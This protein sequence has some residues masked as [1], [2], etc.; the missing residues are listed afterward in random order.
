[1]ML[2]TEIGNFSSY[3]DLY[4]EMQA[5]GVKEV[6]C[7]VEYWLTDV[8]TSKLTLEAVKILMEHEKGKEELPIELVKKI[9]RM[10]M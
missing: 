5:I 4:Y 10:T 9:A 6:K 2:K 7:T 3:K 1:M 8:L